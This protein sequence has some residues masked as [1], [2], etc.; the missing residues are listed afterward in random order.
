MRQ[1]LQKRLVEE[2]ELRGTPG[3]TR[4][5]YTYCIGRF[6]Q[7]FGRSAATLGRAEVR[8]FLVH[9]AEQQKVSAST[10][11]VYASAL[12]FLYRHVLERPRAVEN[13]GRRKLV[14][15]V[16][17][18][19]TPGEVERLLG[20]MRSPTHRVV[21]MLCFGAGLRIREALGLRV[22][23]IDAEA[24]VL[25]I[26][27][28]KRGRE[29]DVMLSP[30]LLAELRAYWRWRRPP[31][32]ELFPGQAGAGTTLTRAAVSRAFKRALAAAGLEGRRV[33]PHTLRHSFATSLLEQGTDLRTVQVLLG[34][35]S[36]G[37]TVRYVHVSTARLR[38]VSSPLDRL[39]PV[40]AVPPL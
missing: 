39:A 13:L 15:R 34:H 25:H 38:G 14:R 7:H 33:T 30:R 12:Y 31:G 20:A 22:E 37:S 24:G 19:L 36:I 40:R 17:A 23:D 6:E 9:L 18:V 32:R 5:T 8:R 4:R 26:R 3:N 11:N 29:R 35:A 16:A 27:R 28:A 10:S 21:A 1:R 2:F